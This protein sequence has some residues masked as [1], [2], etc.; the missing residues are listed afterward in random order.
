M[1]LLNS[2]LFPRLASRSVALPSLMSGVA[3]VALTLLVGCPATA[4]ADAQQPSVEVYPD[5]APP[6]EPAGEQF[7][8]GRPLKAGDLTLPP[9]AKP[10][11]PTKIC[12]PTL[13][14][15]QLQAPQIKP[16]SPPIYGSSQSSS[17]SIML[18]QGMKKALQQSGQNPAVPLSSAV[19]AVVPASPTAAPPPFHP[20]FAPQ[21]ATAQIPAP[22]LM[23][24]QLKPDQISLQDALPA[25]APVTAAIA[26]TPLPTQPVPQP[27]TPYEPGRE[28][29]NLAAEAKP[30]DAAT[31][32]APAATATAAPTSPTLPTTL[33][34]LQ[35]PQNLVAATATSAATEDGKCGA[36]DGISYDI[37]PNKDLC[38]KGTV[39]AVQGEGPWTWGCAG[40]NGG[41]SAACGATKKIDAA[42]GSAAKSGQHKVPTDNLCA[43]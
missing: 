26:Q 40:I 20:E 38:S 4:Y 21:P 2:P 25:P 14:V 33:G 36:A 24:V 5:A 41:N 32:N 15:G 12:P 42:C 1:T 19:S 17:E 30:T 6:Q 31:A 34:T 18:L 39:G 35:Q 8:T 28:P 7:F 29:H 10:Q 37:A 13:P 43:L 22:R 9:L 27:Q 3:F 11:Q 23:P 16:Q